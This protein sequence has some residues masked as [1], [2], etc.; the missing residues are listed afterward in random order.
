MCMYPYNF[1]TST[2]IVNGFSLGHNSSSSDCAI[3]RRDHS[4]GTLLWV[5]QREGVKV[6]SNVVAWSVVGRC[7]EHHSVSVQPKCEQQRKYSG[8]RLIGIRIKGIFCSL[9][10]FS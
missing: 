2:Y 4:Q 7:L 3:A 9:G 5:V 1:V 10:F 8:F 6:G